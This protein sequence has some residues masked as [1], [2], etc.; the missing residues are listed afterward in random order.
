MYK[1]KKEEKRW[2]RAIEIAKAM[3]VQESYHTKY[4]EEIEDFVRSKKMYSPRIKAE[5]IPKL[6]ELAKTRK[7]PMT[8]LVNKIIEEYLTK[9]EGKKA[10]SPQDG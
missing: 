1:D 7:V 2:Y 4:L 3:F 5:L 8:R 6:Y 10:T 9:E